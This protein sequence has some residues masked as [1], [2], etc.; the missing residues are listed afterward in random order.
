MRT[1]VQ[2]GRRNIPKVCLAAATRSE[3]A[4]GGSPRDGS[5]PQH[6]APRAGDA[7]ERSFGT[8]VETGR[9]RYNEGESVN[10]RFDASGCTRAAVP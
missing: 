5:L 6:S 8:G 4:R 9:S 10:D 2:S 3:R 1:P 7:C